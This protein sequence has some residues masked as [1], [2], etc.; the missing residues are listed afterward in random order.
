MASGKAHA[1]STSTVI[2]IATV[3]IV[4]TFAPPH[5]VAFIAG[6]I[7]GHYATPDVRD[8]H[9]SVNEG[10]RMARRDFGKMAGRLWTLIWWL[11]AKAIPHRSW[12]SHLPGPAT[13]LAAAWLY[14]VPLLALWMYQQQWFALLWSL[15][16]WH[17]AGWALQDAVH[18]AQDGWRVNW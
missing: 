5:I 3:I 14:G 13:L 2:V 11:P 1:R 9:Q 8:Q 6:L 10:E 7:V 17:V 18:L 16:W 4:A 12:L 15:K